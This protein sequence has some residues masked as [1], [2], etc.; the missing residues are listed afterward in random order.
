MVTAPPMKDLYLLWC[1]A[2]IRTSLSPWVIIAM[3]LRVRHGRLFTFI[4]HLIPLHYMA[5]LLQCSGLSAHG[6]PML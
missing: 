6:V 4:M 1:M 5:P 3:E 2:G